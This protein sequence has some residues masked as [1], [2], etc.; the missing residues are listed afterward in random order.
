MSTDLALVLFIVLVAAIVVWGVRRPYK[1]QHA[2]ATYYRRPGDRFVDARKKPVADPT[3]I[4]S[5][6]ASYEARK[7]ED[8]AEASKWGSAPDSD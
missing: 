6:K 3:L 8:N 5:L 7:A 4:A 2:G 1:F